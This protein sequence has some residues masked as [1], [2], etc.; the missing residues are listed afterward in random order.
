MPQGRKPDVGK[1]LFGN[2]RIRL[3]NMDAAAGVLLLR[4]VYDEREY[5]DVVY[6]DVFY[7]QLD[8]SCKNVF[9][10]IAQREDAAELAHTRH[11]GSIR[12]MMRDCQC[13]SSFVLE[14][15]ENRGYRFYTHYAGRDDEYLIIAK[16]MSIKQR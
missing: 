1:M 8:E 7:T 12:R 2:V 3:V 13:T 16:E 11:A 10:T 14:E 15:L 5:M 4:A 9:I 6:Q